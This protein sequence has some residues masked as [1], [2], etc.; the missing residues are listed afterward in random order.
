MLM[1]VM[2]V[3]PSHWMCLILSLHKLLSSPLL[4]SPAACL[5]ITRVIVCLFVVLWKISFGP[6]KT[7]HVRILKRRRGREMEKKFQMTELSQRER[8]RRDDDFYRFSPC[9]VFIVMCFVQFLCSLS[10][11]DRKRFKGWGNFLFLC[12]ICKSFVDSCLKN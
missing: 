4:P 3:S 6:H 2:V 7:T 8:E 9:Y 10:S 11:E 5:L 1:V 12:E